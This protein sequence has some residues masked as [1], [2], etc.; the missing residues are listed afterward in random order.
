[1]AQILNRIWQQEAVHFPTATWPNLVSVYL[2]PLAVLG[3]DLMGDT[4]PLGPQGS[5]NGA[6]VVP[7]RP[8]LESRCCHRRS[9]ALKLQFSLVL[10]MN[11]ECPLQGI[12]R[13]VRWPVPYRHTYVLSGRFSGA[14]E[15][16]GPGARKRSQEGAY[17]GVISRQSP[18]PH[19]PAT[20]MFWF[21]EGP[22]LKEPKKI[23][24]P[25][26]KPGAK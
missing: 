22:E 1:M 26:L 17:L 13:I 15:C 5:R 3:V 18:P 25:P 7:N 6:H 2:C 9:P 21:T 16:E 23:D 20:V 10:S 4:S 14:V 19:V 12:S 8:V 11:K 24:G